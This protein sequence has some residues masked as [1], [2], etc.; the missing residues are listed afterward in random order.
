MFQHEQRRIYCYLN[1]KCIQYP[2]YFL[3]INKRWAFPSGISQILSLHRPW[4]R[5]LSAPSV[6]AC[7]SVWAPPAASVGQSEPTP[8]SDGCRAP[9]AASPAGSPAHTAG[10][11][12]SPSW[13]ILVG[14]SSGQEKWNNTAVICD[15]RYHLWLMKYVRKW[16]M[17]PENQDVIRTH[18]EDKNFTERD[19]KC[20]QL[21][22][23]YIFTKLFL[24][25]YISYIFRISILFTVFLLFLLPW[26]LPLCTARNERQTRHA[27]F[28]C[29]LKKVNCPADGF[30]RPLYSYCLTGHHLCL[31][32]H[33]T[34][35]LNWPKRD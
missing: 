28:F 29:Y 14:P 19:S 8:P 15:S 10:T 11:P 17:R 13:W 20:L 22:Q 18:R 25:I 34:T 21:T 1:K 4:H 5:T 35:V 9:S 27:M 26:N 24:V 33:H 30:H 7:G 6:W 32:F 16:D 23:I 3:H 2:H 31:F 12:R